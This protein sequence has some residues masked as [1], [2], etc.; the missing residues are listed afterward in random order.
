MMNRPGTEAKFAKTQTQHPHVHA[1]IQLLFHLATNKIM[2]VITYV[3]ASKL[4]CVLCATV[5]QIEGT[6]TCRI[7]HDHLYPRWMVP[8]LKTLPRDVRSRVWT[9]IAR[10]RETLRAT[11]LFVPEKGRNFRPESTVD[12]TLASGLT[13]ATLGTMSLEYRLARK[14]QQQAEEQGM[15]SRYFD[16][17][18][19]E[20][21]EYTEPDKINDSS[22]STVVQQTQSETAD[23]QDECGGCSRLT[24]RQCSRC[25]LDRFCSHACEERMGPTHKFKCSNGALTTAD[26]LMSDCIGDE[27]PKDPDVLTDFGFQRLLTFPDRS[28]LLGL[29]KDLT[30]LDV[31]AEELHEWQISG[32]LAD[33]IIETFERV[34]PGSRGRYF[35]WFVEN[36]HLIFPPVPKTHAV[37]D[38]DISEHYYKPAKFLLEPTDRLKPVQSL[39]P[40][41][42]RNC[43]MFAA[44]I[45][46]SQHPSPE[47]PGPYYDFGFCA[48]MNEAD[49]QI[50]GVL[51]QRLIIDDMQQL[52][53]LYWGDTPTSDA[54]AARFSDF[55]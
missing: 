38:N 4:P 39:E 15:L 5:L 32:R 26:Y 45:I 43:F 51:Y 35:L 42:K 23:Y 46:Q 24:R 50:L 9:V 18:K 2:G 22:D 36:R 48:C 14:Q 10:L 13:T 11:L 6:L 47:L 30:Y 28:K 31:E 53:R 49:E 44:L 8:D 34:P 3:G 20:T 40:S 1:E 19:P 12:M 37:T 54:Y 41:T 25:G 16:L 55:C 33:R 17:H 27:I 29:Y 21:P 52:Q 7:S